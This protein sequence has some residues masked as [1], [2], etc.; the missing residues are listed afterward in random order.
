MI[1]NLINSFK[2][3]GNAR[4]LEELQVLKEILD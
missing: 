4:K 1:N 2:E 3:V